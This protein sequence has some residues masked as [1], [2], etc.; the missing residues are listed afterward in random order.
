MRNAPTFS[1]IF[2]VL[3]PAGVATAEP[4]G[5]VAAPASVSPLTVQAPPEP[6]VVQKQTHEFVLSVAAASPA[7][8]QIARWHS[9]ICISVAG[10]PPDQTKRVSSRITE[11][12]ENL[13]VHTLPPSCQ[14]NI[15]IVFTDKPQ[16]FMD[17]V[18]ATREELLGY[19]HRNQKAALKTVTRPA[20]AWYTTST[21]SGAIAPNSSL[22]F[23][24][25]TTK[26]PAS[27]GVTI[28]FQPKAEVADDPDNPVP[29]GCSEAPQFTH[30]ML[31]K[32]SNVLIVV[33]PSR[34]KDKT[35]G[36]ITDYL[37]MLALSQMRSLDGCAALPSVIDR[38]GKPCGDR[39]LPDGIT[40]ADAAY[41][42][43]LYAS[44]LEK[45]KPLEQDEISRR[46]ADILIKANAPAGR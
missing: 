25:I 10:L 32:L 1:L 41:L 26:G 16:A 18:A 36:P 8:D 22:A 42:T 11:V 20:Q 19:Y 13:G 45:N 7:I 23:A 4:A 27:T 9:A 12:A 24:T 21:D 35:L 3:L 15:E 17:T 38:L 14:A 28:H 2:S 5:P 31:S 37:S 44:D 34:L 39:Q 30:C 6:A 46:M 40:S 33:D 43:S 29:T